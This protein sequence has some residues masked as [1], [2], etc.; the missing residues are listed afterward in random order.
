MRNTTLSYSAV[1]LFI[2]GSLCTVAGG[3]LRAGSESHPP[4]PP[5]DNPSVQV[6]S[7]TVEPTRIY[8]GHQPHSAVV[9]VQLM[10]RGQA[11]ADA[12]AKVEV[13]TYSADPPG[14]NVNYSKAQS[15]SLK[16]SP[17]ILKFTVEASSKTVPGKVILA[18]SVDETTGGVV[19]K[20][21][22][23]SKDWHA[24]LAFSD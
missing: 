14:N 7:V 24:E 9:T 19:V 16:D 10:L 2:L 3:G 6:T 15:V 18:A 8:K 22:E 17:L 5:P 11:P 4:S 13:A 20:E 23:T 1:L 12:R 21:P